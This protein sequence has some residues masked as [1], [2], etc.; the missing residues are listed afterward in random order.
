MNNSFIASLYFLY[1]EI[2]SVDGLLAV[3]VN[4]NQVQYDS[5]YVQDYADKLE[6]SEKAKQLIAEVDWAVLPDVGLQNSSEFIHYR[7]VLRNFIKNP[8]PNPIFPQKP[9]EIW[10]V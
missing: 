10:S 9:T 6:C 1:P 7:A 4:G 5:I 8:V 3:D 2:V